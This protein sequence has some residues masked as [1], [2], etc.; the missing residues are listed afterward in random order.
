MLSAMVCREMF[1]TQVMLPVMGDVLAELNPAQAKAVRHLRGPLMVLAGAG[2]GK[3]RVITRRIAWVLKS[4]VQPGQILALTFTNKA[5]G[6]MARRVEVLGGHHVHVSTFH[7][8]CARFLRAD[9]HFLD[10]P[11]NFSIYDTYDRDACIKQLLFAEGIPLGGV[12]TANRVGTRISRLK[13]LG[14]R[15]AEFVAGLGELD[16]A[17][18]KIY[19]KYQRR[20]QEL[21]AMDF[22]DLLLRFVDLLVEHPAVAEIYQERFQHV[23]VDEFQDTN[24]IQYRLVKILA[25]KHRNLCVVGDPDQ[26]IYKFRGADIRN[27]LDFD[28]DYPD[29]VTIRLET[30]YRSTGCILAA[31]QAV[32]ENNHERKEKIL[33]TDA[34]FGVPLEI[35]RSESEQGEA[36]DLT[37]AV[38]ELIL[39]GVEPDQIAIFYRAHFLSRSVEQSL[40]QSGLPYE[41]VGGLS[42]FE[43]REIKD[44]LAYLRVLVNPLD[45]ISMLRVVN[46]P[47]RGVG[48]VSLQKLIDRAADEE[49]SLFEALAEPEVRAVASAQARKGLTALAEVFCSIRDGDPPHQVIRQI[50]DGTDYMQFA[51]KLG[52]PQEA[53]RE[54]NILELINDAAHF[55]KLGGGDPRARLDRTR[56][57]DPVRHLFLGQLR[58]DLRQVRPRLA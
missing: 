42:F 54:D 51:N 48:K 32:I 9:G 56:V 57:P 47:P 11:Q 10:Y 19:E 45:D 16:G 17:V 21:G 12:V 20:M 43:R 38:R 49:M 15:P 34:E 58:L 33:R 46:V 50:L 1:P 53:S 7:S 40:R 28:A 29:A 6:E 37:L 13:N 39:D 23:M 3:T 4:G 44:V 41:I 18:S 22:D 8:A 24:L 5:A 25:E 2:S 36:A 26:S 35:T 52:D 30:N 31:A 14:V 55:A 27:I